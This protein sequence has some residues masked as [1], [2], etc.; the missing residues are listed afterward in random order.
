MDN[1]VNG[2]ARQ[3][4]W[5]RATIFCMAFAASLV[6]LSGTAVAGAI[7][8]CGSALRVIDGKVFLITYLCD[9]ET[10]GE[11]GETSQFLPGIPPPPKGPPSGGQPKLAP[12]RGWATPAT[13]KPI[14]CVALFILEVPQDWSRETTLE[15]DFGDGSPRDSI[16]I[17]RG[18]G[19]ATIAL[20]HTF[21][22]SPGYTWTQRATILETGA[23][24][25]SSTTHL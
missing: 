22:P 6:L 23:F 12:A 19:D 1:H 24:A 17:P 10:G 3:G 16:P 5:R 7:V 9:S 13:V 4:F 25:Q 20:K 8:P 11:V 14:A 2:L 15:M 18:T 21:P